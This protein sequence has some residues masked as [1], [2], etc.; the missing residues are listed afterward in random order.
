MAKIPRL[1]SRQGAENHVNTATSIE[2]GN[3]AS[4]WTG[5]DF[6]LRAVDLLP[7]RHALAALVRAR[8]MRLL[9]PLVFGTLVIV[10]PQFYLQIVEALGYPAAAAWRGDKRC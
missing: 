6:S 5:A 3:D 8:S 2:P 7:R 1:S 4:I 9:V 10:P